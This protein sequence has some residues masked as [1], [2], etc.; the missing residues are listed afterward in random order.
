MTQA[1]HCEPESLRIGV[2]V[3]RCGG[4]ISDVVDTEAVVEAA[5]SIRRRGHCQGQ[6]LH[7]FRSRAGDDRRGHQE[8]TPESRSG[9]LLLAVPARADVSHR[10]AARRV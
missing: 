3:C 9:R 4:N 5:K 10:S 8:A 2:Y 6:H 1:R 7:V